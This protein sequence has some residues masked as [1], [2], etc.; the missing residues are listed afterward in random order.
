MNTYFKNESDATEYLI[1][2]VLPFLN[3]MKEITPSGKK[4]IQEYILLKIFT[5][6]QA[7]GGII[8]DILKLNVK[9][10]NGAY[11]ENTEAKKLIKCVESTAL[12][13]SIPSVLFDDLKKQKSIYGIIKSI[14]DFISK[15]SKYFIP[16]D[17]D[18]LKKLTFEACEIYDYLDWL[19]FIPLGKRTEE[20]KS[21]MFHRKEN[22]EQA[23]EY[24]N[25]DQQEKVF[26]WRN[27]GNTVLYNFKLVKPESANLDMIKKIATFA[28]VEC[29]TSTFFYDEIDEASRLLELTEKIGEYQALYKLSYKRSGFDKIGC[30]GYCDKYFIKERTNQ[31]YCSK[32]CKDSASS[33]RYRN[34]QKAETESLKTEKEKILNELSKLDINELSDLKKHLKKSKK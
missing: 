31:D 26:K 24:L 20:D 23:A 5:L 25:D 11:L 30:C 17:K 27:I 7:N 14:K 32:S 2:Y 3:S 19:L 1:N 34:K 15:N 33:A 10:T 12:T 16:S 9:L 6:Y 18:K 22:E 13:P 21:K 4:A 28:A 8:L 29:L